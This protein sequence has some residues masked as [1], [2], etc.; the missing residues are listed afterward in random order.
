MPPLHPIS[1]KAEI[2]VDFQDKV[3]LGRFSRH[4]QFSSYADAESVTIRFVRP[5]EDRREAV[6]HLHYGLAE[7]RAELARSLSARA[8]LE[9]RSGAAPG[10]A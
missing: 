6:S 7:I 10:A 8:P 9:P 4:S 1:D 3:Y 2:S 5:D